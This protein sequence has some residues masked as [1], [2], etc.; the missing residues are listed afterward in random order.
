LSRAASKQSPI[1][2]RDFAGTPA[3]ARDSSIAIR[4]AKSSL[5]LRPRCGYDL[6]PTGSTA[7]AGAET[8]HVGYGRTGAGIHAA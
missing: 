8:Q 4:P 3:A 2:I 7:P 1:K 5:T 6:G